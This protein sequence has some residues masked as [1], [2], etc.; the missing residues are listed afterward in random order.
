MS[1]HARRL[2]QASRGL[3][4][5]TIAL[6]VACSIIGIVVVTLL[7]CRLWDIRAQRNRAAVLEAGSCM[8]QHGMDKKRRFS[9]GEYGDLA[10]VQT[11]KRQR[12]LS[13]EIEDKWMRVIKGAKSRA[14]VRE[15]VE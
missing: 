1:E 6:I 12:R 14:D 10:R 11:A 7:G 3:S 8:E 13:Q 9:T 5:V 2:L 15:E 4:S